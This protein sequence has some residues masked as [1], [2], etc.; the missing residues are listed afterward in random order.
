MTNEG[1]DTQGE[2]SIR[3]A[4]N[5]GASSPATCPYAVALHWNS[6]DD[7]VTSNTTTMTDDNE[8]NNHHTKFSINPT[9]E[10]KRLIQSCPAFQKGHCPFASCSN[11]HEIRKMLLQIPSSH[12][13]HQN[14]NKEELIV[15][16]VTSTATTTDPSPSTKN[17]QEQD[18]AT[19]FLKVLQEL[20][21]VVGI[22]ATTTTSTSTSN[23]T[24][25]TNTTDTGTSSILSFLPN[26]C[27]VLSSSASSSISNQV[28]M[29][30][31]TSVS[32]STT[33]FT[34]VIMDGYSLAEIMARLAKEVEEEEENEDVELSEGHDN[35][36]VHSQDRIQ[37]T[38]KINDP[39]TIESSNVVDSVVTIPGRS[40]K[41]EQQQEQHDQQQHDRKLSVTIKSGTAASH[42]AAENV[43]FVRNFIRGQIDPFLFAELTCKLYYVYN[44]LEY[45]I[46]NDPNTK[47]NVYLQQFFK[48][49]EQLQRTETLKE[50]L[51][52]W[53]GTNKAEQIITSAQIDPN[54]GTSYSNNNGT[55]FMSEATKDY[56]DRIQYC[57]ANNP[58][59]LLAHSYTRYLGDLSGGKILARVARKALQLSNEGDGLAF[60]D[61][62]STITNAKQFKD[63]YRLA[64][65][66]LFPPLSDYE[67]QLLVAEANIAFC[68]N[69]R[70]FEELD[71]LANVPNAKLRPLIEAIEPYTISKAD[72]TNDKRGHHHSTT[73]GKEIPKECPF[74]KLSQMSND[75]VTTTTTTPTSANTTTSTIKKRCPWPFIIF[76]DPIE[77]LH[78][79]QTWMV[80]GLVL[81]WLYHQ[82]MIVQSSSTTTMNA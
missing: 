77:A 28:Q 72:N 37:Q 3:A 58:L 13:N 9:N 59:L 73:E 70:L 23:D 7:T 50:D 27:P 57:V 38:D 69:M 1:E 33:K 78:D 68:L 18:I 80:F 20:H 4:M 2:V 66:N 12:Y 22:V 29:K 74:A 15:D 32:T 65:D 52:Y 60:Y 17:T 44:T 5:D 48:F 64:L 11:E 34:Y 19:P 79:W 76:H 41:Q 46:L 49:H 63:D 40:I 36:T 31:R 42:V 16:A 75:A 53:F 14:N 43:H 54:T 30:T 55:T 6:D 81:C 61:F 71:V 21:S 67:I 25:S 56:L 45:Y 47:Q 35:T 62:T 39:T 8:S 82:F 51:D 26:K 24:Q 10:T